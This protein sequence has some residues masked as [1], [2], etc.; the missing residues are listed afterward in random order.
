WTRRGA[1]DYPCGVLGD[2]EPRRPLAPS[3]LET[4]GA[5]TLPAEQPPEQL[6]RPTPQPVPA[7]PPERAAPQPFSAEP[8]RTP[9]VGRSTALLTALGSLALCWASWTLLGEVRQQRRLTDTLLRTVSAPEIAF[10][11]PTGFDPDAPSRLTV[12][13]HNDGGAAEEV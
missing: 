9:G 13:V 7:P 1:P 4:L 11:A 6:E 12:G 2:G 10:V 3:V 5:N 8:R